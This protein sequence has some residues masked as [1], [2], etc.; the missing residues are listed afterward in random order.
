MHRL[1]AD[2]AALVDVSSVSHNEHD[3]A[4]AVETRLR[5]SGDHG[6][7]VDRIANN[8]VARSNFGRPSRVVLAGHLDT[9]PPNGNDKARIVGDAVWGLGAS[10]MKGGLA[11]M[12][13]LAAS[14][15]DRTG[16]PSAAPLLDVTFVFYACEEVDRRHSGLLQIEAAAPGL[17]GGDAAVLGEPTGSY[18][19]AGCQG[20]LKAAVTFGGTRAHTARPWMGSNAIHRSAGLLARL[21]S[22]QERR[23]VVD[24]CEYREAL[25]AVSFEAG[26][27]GNVVPDEA[28]VVLNHRYAPDRSDLEAEE[29]LLDWLGPCVDKSR[30]D[31]VRVVD[32]SPSAA[33][34]LSHPALSAL[35]QASGKPPRAKLGWTDVA[36]FAER[37]IPAANFGP[38]DP[39]LA[40]TKDEYVTL[41]DLL[42]V[43]DALAC[44]LGLDLR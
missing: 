37:G 5:S 11:V 16:G 3:M 17:L 18:V 41:S 21:S 10:D 30:G 8:V 12:L 36:F 24:G 34:N 31:T 39:E 9:V 20:V 15:W 40:H 6:L 7:E 29:A 14:L 44:L 33:P 4:N 27:A 19:E 1:L 32:R 23:P 2:V 13:D 35:V 25:Q 42:A 26:V 28:T 38:G 22:Y 43:R